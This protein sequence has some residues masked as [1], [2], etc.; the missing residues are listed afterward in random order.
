MKLSFLI[1]LTS[2]RGTVA[3]EDGFGLTN[4]VTAELMITALSS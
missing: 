1:Y 2:H 4:P 3:G